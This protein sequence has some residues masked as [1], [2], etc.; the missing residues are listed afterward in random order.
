MSVEHES[1]AWV[2]LQLC[3]RIWRSVLRDGCDEHKHKHADNHHIVVCASDQHVI[4][5]W[6]LVDI[7]IIAVDHFHKHAD[8]HHIVD[9]SALSAGIRRRQLHCEA[10][11]QCWIVPTRGDVC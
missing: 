1:A 9:K 8:N 3:G 4:H 7:D 11:L 5:T 10:E 2:Q 6:T